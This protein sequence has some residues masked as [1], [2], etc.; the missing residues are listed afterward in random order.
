LSLTETP[1]AAMLLLG[2][3][4]LGGCTALPTSSTGQRSAPA[5]A[6]VIVECGGEAVGSVE[7][8]G[9]WIPRGELPT[10]QV[11][12]SLSISDPAD[13]GSCGYRIVSADRLR[14]IQI[15]DSRFVLDTA[16]EL[17]LAVSDTGLEEI[18]FD[19]NNRSVGTLRLLV[20]TRA[21]AD[22]AIG[23]KGAGWQRPENTLSAVSA[24]SDAR[25]AASE[26][27]VRLTRD[28]VPVLMHDA[29]ITRTTTGWGSVEAYTAT[30]LGAFDAGIKFGE[31]FRGEVIPTLSAALALAVSSGHR[32]LLDVKVDQSIVSA[33][34]EARV[35]AEIVREA[36]AESLVTIMS[37][38][39][40]F[41]R[42]AR[43]ASGS[44]GLALLSGQGH[45]EWHSQLA[46]EVGA[47]M[48][49]YN[50]DSLL[51]PRTLAA[52]PQ[53]VAG[54]TKLIATTVNGL[55]QADVLLATGFVSGILTDIPPK[56]YDL[57]PQ[58]DQ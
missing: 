55:A 32:L 20:A 44:V 31:R 41:L 8:A 40:E 35:I 36:G 54:G 11:T 45:Y 48:I 27:D 16:L 42:A 53:L 25:L 28:T 10:L 21:F 29:S 13:R 51:L 19:V 22:A 47:A 23:H 3:F 17:T 2:A 14:A 1:V 7:P 26:V 4:V 38:S 56:M 58:G 33:P 50:A 46:R 5:S 18:S 39:R 43:E 57:T 15:A 49:V 12:V 30:E 9:R 37:P 24:A 34:E 52:A 6:Q